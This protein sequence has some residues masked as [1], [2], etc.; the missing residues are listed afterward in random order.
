MGEID[1]KSE[2]ISGSV[3]SIDSGG[4]FCP[5]VVQEISRNAFVVS[6]L[7]PEGISHARKDFC[8]HP[9]KSRFFMT[10]EVSRTVSG[11]F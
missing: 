10:S 6:I 5:R 8:M 9:K 4:I 11:T 1:N 2:Y 7:F 3:S